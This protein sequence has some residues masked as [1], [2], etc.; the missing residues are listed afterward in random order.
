MDYIGRRTE[1]EFLEGT[2]AELGEKKAVYINNRCNAF[3]DPDAARFM[4]DSA[5]DNLPDLNDAEETEQDFIYRTMDGIL[6][7][8]VDSFG[9]SLK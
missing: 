6:D 7:S 1:S 4:A 3:T 2:T 8:L 9:F 5:W